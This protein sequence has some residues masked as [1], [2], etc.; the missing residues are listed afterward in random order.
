M[1]PPKS[2]KSR[3]YRFMGIPGGL[4]AETALARAERNV[5]AHRDAALGQLDVV[6][7][8][9][10]QVLSAPD[11]TSAQSQQR[12]LELAH[13]I[14]GVAGLFQ[15]VALGLAAQSLCELIEGCFER[16]TWDQAGVAVHLAA[17]RLLRR[18]EHAV[19]AAESEVLKGLARIVNRDGRSPT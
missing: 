5:A 14:A 2:R 1:K 7:G 11:G 4:T 19:G 13:E 18:P 8:S 17:I 9:I 16:K 3:L 6:I 12:L 10:D 15:L